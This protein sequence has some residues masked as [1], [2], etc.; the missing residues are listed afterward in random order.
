VVTIAQLVLHSQ[1]L[2]LLDIS[3]LR[4]FKLQMQHA[5][6]ILVPLSTSVISAQDILNLAQAHVTPLSCL[7]RLLSRALPAPTL[8][9]TPLLQPVI[10]TL[11]GLVTTAKKTQPPIHTSQCLAP[12]A[13]TQAPPP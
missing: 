11:V 4:S 2:V 13:P 3:T 5:L 7:P 8:V 1:L 12:K 6:L 10:V 9:T